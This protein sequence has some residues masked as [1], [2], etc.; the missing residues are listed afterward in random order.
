[1][2]PVSSAVVDVLT[3]ASQRPGAVTLRL[4]VRTG[5]TRRIAVSGPEFVFQLTQ[6]FLT[7]LTSKPVLQ[8][9]A[10]LFHSCPCLQRQ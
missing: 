6:S 5:L 7:T 4:T 2:A 3:S 8:F 1:M 10:V 9:L